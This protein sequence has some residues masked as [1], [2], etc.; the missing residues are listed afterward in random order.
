MPAYLAKFRFVLLFSFCAAAACGPS[1]VY[2]DADVPQLPKLED[3]MW[4]QAQAADPQFKKIGNPTYSDVDYAQFTALSVRL[5]ATTGRIKKD[6]SKGP[7]FDSFADTLN[8]RATELADASGARDAV[9]A[10][11]A[12]QAMKDTCRACHKKFR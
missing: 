9:K 8:Q 11:A 12:L 1:Q 3:V 10:S 2:S 5:H 6:F 4:S 7:E